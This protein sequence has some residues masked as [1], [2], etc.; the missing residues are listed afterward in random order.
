MTKLSDLIKKENSFVTIDGTILKTVFDL[1]KYLSTCDE[2][3]YQYHVNSEKNDFALWAKE[4]LVSKELADKLYATPKLTEAIT[5]INEYLK[6]F[7]YQSKNIPDNKA[8]YTRE[9]FNLKNIQELYYYINNCEEDSFYYHANTEKNDFANWVNEV[10]SFPELALKMRKISNRKDMCVLLKHFL[11]NDS[12]S[13]KLEYDKYIGERLDIEIEKDIS[14]DSKE[15]ILN[16]KNAF[17]ELSKE[18]GNESENDKLQKEN[19]ILVNTPNTEKVMDNNT[20]NKTS[21]DYLTTSSTNSI[22]KTINEETIDLTI[23]PNLEPEEEPEKIATPDFDMS[24]FKQFTDEELEKFVVF[25][26]KEELTS[27]NTKIEYLKSVLQEL[28]VMVHNLRR[29]EKD[30][31]IAD[32]MLRGINAKIDYYALSQNIEDYNHIIR[33]FKDVQHE[34]EECANQKSY[35][36][37]EEIYNDLKFQAIALKKT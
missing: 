22:N 7:D 4:V 19:T 3:S 8:F 15:K 23:K 16:S 20:L 9:T 14:K 11:L 17:D 2:K 29:I 27:P 10:L 18:T 5:V 37:A 21:S 1:K 30:P 24:G 6:N 26:K 36:L 35:N 25:S 32:L 12:N 34:I 28:N 13:S 33:I 31:L